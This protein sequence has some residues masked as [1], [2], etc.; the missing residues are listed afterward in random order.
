MMAGEGMVARLAAERDWTDGIVFPASLSG[1][2]D[3]V[4]EAVMSAESRVFRAHRDQLEGQTRILQQKSVQLDEEIRGLNAQIAAE[5]MQLKLI[6]E[7]IGAVQ[8]MVAKGLEPKP[9]PL[10]LQRQSAG[11]AGRPG[12]TSAQ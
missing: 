11:I 12:H 3:P 7:E 4:A 8:Q 1:L 6:G 5:E 10:A 9:K 2:K